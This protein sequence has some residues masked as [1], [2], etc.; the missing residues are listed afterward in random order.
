MKTNTQPEIS[1]V[2][3]E[4]DQRIANI[5][6]RFVERISGFT[7]IG[8]AHTADETEDFLELYQPDLLLLDV[9]FP[10]GNGIEILSRLRNAKQPTDVIL[11]TAA[12]EIETLKSAMNFGVFDYILKPLAFNRLQSALERFKAHFH[13]LDE[14]TDLYQADVDKILHGNASTIATNNTIENTAKTRHPKGIDEITLKNIVDVFTIGSAALDRSQEN[15]YSAE[16]VAVKIGA[17]RTTARRYLEYLV[18][19][20]VL[21]AKINYGT[22]GRPERKY[23]KI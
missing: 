1:I 17:S 21:S 2:I 8:I 15:G 16:E 12:S 18:S 20:E 22:V 9:H 5:Q 23:Q 10:S 7:V 14:I 6:Q 3:A 4:D 13:Q 19:Q 11:I